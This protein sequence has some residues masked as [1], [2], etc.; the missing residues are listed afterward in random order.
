LKKRTA[1]VFDMDG[2]MVDTE[3]LS[4]QAWA[5]V[6][7]QY[8]HTLDDGT[9]GRMIGHRSDV[10]AQVLLDRY[11]IPL[12]AGE[13]ISRKEAVFDGFRAKGV[14]VMPGLMA[15]QAEIGRRK[16]SWA[17]ATSSS[18]HHAQLILNQLSLA[19]SCQA[20]AAGD[21]VRSG[22]PAP[23]IYLLAAERLNISPEL[24]LALEDSL[25]G[26]QSALAAGMRVVAIP[27]PHTNK[28]D[29]G[30]VH[31]VFDS[32]YEVADSLDQVL[33]TTK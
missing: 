16:L 15:L 14:P 21:E 5:K 4:R 27:N 9:Y 24:C 17:V 3:P 26:M 8:G 18:R 22:K 25:P 1:I 29:F 32:L 20:I 28:S 19:D 33:S 30:A 10:S 6:L 11:A 2:L 31:H 13:L 7:M 23:D 12:T